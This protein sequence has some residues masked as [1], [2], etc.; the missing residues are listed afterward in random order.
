MKKYLFVSIGSF[1]LLFFSF[2]FW[3][4]IEAPLISRSVLYPETTPAGSRDPLA[5]TASIIARS[6]R[7]NPQILRILFYGQS[8]T[9]PNW[10][11]LAAAHLRKTYPNTRFEIRNMALGGFASQLLERTVERDLSEFYPDLVVFHAYGDHRAYERIVQIIRSRTA[12]ELIL[13]TDHVTV[14]V[15]PI[16]AEGLY[17]ALRP[18]PG[19]KGFIWYRQ[20]SWEEFMSDTMIPRLTSLYG[21][22][23]E[24]RRERWNAYLAQH[25]LKPQALLTDAIHP[26]ES[27]WR[28]MAKIFEA[29]F[30]KAMTNYRGGETDLVS[31]LPRRTKGTD[32]SFEGNRVEVIADGPLDGKITA[33]IDGTSASDLEGCWITTR[34][35]PLVNLTDWPAVRRVTVASDIKQDETWTAKI[36]DLNADQSDFSFILTSDKSGPD[37]AGR[38]SM[39]F[40]SASGRVRIESRDWTIRDAYALV[41]RKLPDGTQISWSRRFVC[42]DEPAITTESD[43]KTLVRHVLAAGLRNSAHELTLDVAPEAVPL[44]RELRVYRPPLHE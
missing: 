35:T 38:G 18:P 21:A 4:P 22:A 31:T 13:Q 16:C 34:A 19:C 3:A 30:D 41:K 5:Q 43:D 27:G 1:I 39:D 44:I 14:P 23:I 32:Y 37:G 25:E 7:E 28:L 33:M 24:P 20:N 26:N 2:A 40:T 8:I 15:E 17:I 12:A 6:T 11:D 42:H 36:T 9:S 10:T 29:N